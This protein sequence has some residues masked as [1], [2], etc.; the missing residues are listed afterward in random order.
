[1]GGSGEVGALSILLK[2]ALDIAFLHDQDLFAVDH[3]LGAGPLAEQDSVADAEVRRPELQPCLLGREP[4]S[5]MAVNI[6]DGAN[7]LP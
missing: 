2:H 3:D 4:T 7:L 1:M 5:G 6:I